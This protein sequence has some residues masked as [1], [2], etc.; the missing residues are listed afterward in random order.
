VGGLRA[1]VLCAAAALVVGPLQACGSSESSSRPAPGVGL[2][3]VVPDGALGGAIHQ[4]SRAIEGLQGELMPS[5]GAVRAAACH[6][7]ENWLDDHT[8]VTDT[9]VS[10]NAV[11]L[12]VAELVFSGEVD[13]ELARLAEQQ[14]WR[15]GPEITLNADMTDAG[16]DQSDLDDYLRLVAQP[17]GPG[18][19]D[20]YVVYAAASKMSTFLVVY[21]QT[22]ALPTGRTSNGRF[23][24]VS[25]WIAADGNI[26]GRTFPQD[27]CK[28]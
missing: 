13:V 14:R 18:A 25:A 19:S 6:N 10:S 12:R 4:D 23:P 15:A 22:A 11:L 9:L 5:G 17:P 1:A 20:T 21:A 24:D 27:D 2:E 3:I 7:L 26:I 16:F 8:L 28:S